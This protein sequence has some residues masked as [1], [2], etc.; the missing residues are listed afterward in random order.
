MVAEV[1]LTITRGLSE[2]K[3]FIF[4]E[5]S[6]GMVGRA[7]GSLLRLPN[8]PA[9]VDVSRRHCL[10]DIDPPLI[11]V[12]DLGSKNGTYVNGANIGQRERGLPPEVASADMPEYA[13]EEGDELRVGGTIFRVSISR[14]AAESRQ[15]TETG[16]VLSSGTSA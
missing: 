5:R 13:L 16:S 4:H 11:H 2:G 15:V 6:I 10:L 7:E 3:V 12:R 1:R 8:S 14:E 9:T